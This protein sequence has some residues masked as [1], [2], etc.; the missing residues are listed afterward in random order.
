MKKL[1][2]C[3][4]TLTPLLLLAACGSELP[5]ESVYDVADFR[6]DKHKV[7]RAPEGLC[8]PPGSASYPGTGL[9]IA[10]PVCPPGVICCAKLGGP[11]TMY[12]SP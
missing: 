11:V 3:L 1:C 7:A 8:E 5:P 10:R 9:V 2:D 12:T 6:A 4:A